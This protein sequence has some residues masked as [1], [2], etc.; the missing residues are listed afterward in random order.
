MHIF[1][2]PRFSLPTNS[3]AS[4]SPNNSKSNEFNVTILDNKVLLVRLATE[5]DRVAHE[6]RGAIDQLRQDPAGFIRSMSVTAVHLVRRQLTPTNL[7]GYTSALLV[8][9]SVVLLITTFE[10]RYE[11]P[12]AKIITEEIERPLLLVLTPNVEG[13]ARIYPS[14]PGRVGLTAGTG[15]GSSPVPAHAQGGGSGGAQDSLPEQEGKVPQPSEVPA[16]IPIDSPKYAPSLPAAGVDLDPKLWADV[17]FPRYGNPYSQVAFRSHGPGDD[18]GIGSKNG[19]GIGDGSGNG[20]GDG[21]NGNTGGG[22]RQ[23]GYGGSGGNT[24]D[25]EAS[26]GFARSGYGGGFDERVR[27]IAKP[28][29][30]YTEEA[31]RQGIVGTV[32]LRVIF[33]NTGEITQIRTIQGLPLGLTERAIA[34][35]REIRFISAKKNGR[36]VSVYMQLEY[37]FNLY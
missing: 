2:S 16:V 6:L 31:R 23:I 1:N 24:G 27:L 33:S 13:R 8:I 12:N 3:K 25:G 35:A 30:H 19:F 20:L 34:A 7:V 10:R 26:D 15:E 4:E 21:N 28:E 17:N 14:S 9:T 11:H 18:G 5:L 36:P 37:N 32:V 29:P 22:N